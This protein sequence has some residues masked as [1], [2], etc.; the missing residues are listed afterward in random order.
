MVISAWKEGSET[1]A[2][3]LPMAALSKASGLCKSLNLGASL[4]LG[5]L[6]KLEQRERNS[7]PRA[8]AMLS[9][10]PG[11]DLLS[12]SLLHRSIGGKAC[13]FPLTRSSVCG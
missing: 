3:R 1:Q 4:R 10:P 6:V 11:E 9:N 12:R 2:E 8:T 7:T 13:G 5:Q